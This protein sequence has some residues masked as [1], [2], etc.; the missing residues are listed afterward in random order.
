MVKANN[1]IIRPVTGHHQVVHP[2]KMG[3]WAVQPTNPFSLDVG[4]IIRICNFT[5]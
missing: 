3:W 5:C 4:F 1:Y 2:M